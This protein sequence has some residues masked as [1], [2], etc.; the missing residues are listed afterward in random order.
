MSIKINLTDENKGD[1]FY[2]ESIKTLR[3]NIQFSGR[4]RRKILF[5]SAFTG[6]GKSDVS[7]HLAEEMAN[8]GKKVLLIDADIR[9]SVFKDRY[10][11]ENAPSGLSEYL[12]GQTEDPNEIIC[13]T[14]YPN[15]YLILAGAYA[16]NPAEMLSDDQFRILLDS[17][18]KVFDYVFI[19]SPP[20]GQVID[21]AVMA[22]FCDGAVIVLESGAVSYRVAQ[23][24]K[25]QLEMTGC[26]ILGVVLNKVDRGGRGAYGK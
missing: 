1:F 16:P 10:N 8:A 13:R 18:A 2:R 6:E 19:D 4:K 26:T 24:I 20:L 23:R 25:Q 21:A 12:S 9:N 22:Q 3:A 5:T 15:L 11:I 14:N 17:S 7:F